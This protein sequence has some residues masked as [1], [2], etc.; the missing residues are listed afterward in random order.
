VWKS[1][2]AALAAQT[3]LMITVCHFPPG[4]IAG[5][6]GSARVTRQTPL[7]ECAVTSKVMVSGLDLPV[8]R[9]ARCLR[10]ADRMASP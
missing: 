6:C 1:E 3:G 5:P 9:C 10:I 7:Q 4:S 2:L 8:T